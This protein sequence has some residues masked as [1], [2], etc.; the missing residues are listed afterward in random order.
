MKLRLLSVGKP[1][2]AECIRLYGRYVERIK[3]FGVP[4]DAAWVRETDADGRYSD[5]HVRQRESKALLDRVEARSRLIAL[6]PRGDL[7]DSDQLA[8]RLESWATPSATLLVGGPLGLS[9]EATERADLRWSLSP[10]TFPHEMARVLVA[11][12]LYRALTILRRV[13]YHK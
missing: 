10:L 7:L 9:P 4:F 5:A 6:D 2:D 3:R 11:E 1:R 8:R 13:P 12:Q